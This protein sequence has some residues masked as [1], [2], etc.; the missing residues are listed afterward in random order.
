M[1]SGKVKQVVQE[2]EELP[3]ETNSEFRLNLSKT[4][5]SFSIYFN[6]SS[7]DDIYTGDE[8]I[9]FSERDKEFKAILRQEFRE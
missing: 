3:H 1:S 8:E 2:I 4:I 5:V 6:K 9:P 7:S